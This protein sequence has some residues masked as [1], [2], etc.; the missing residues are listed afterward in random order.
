MAPVTATSPPLVQEPRPDERSRAAAAV[1]ARFDR[2]LWQRLEEHDG[3]LSAVVAGTLHR[4]P[5]SAPG[6]CAPPRWA[7]SRTACPRS[8]VGYGSAS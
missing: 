7:C 3:V 5:R 4:R 8:T 1:R 6:R 2:V